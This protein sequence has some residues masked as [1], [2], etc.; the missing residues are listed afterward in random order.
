VE[1]AQQVKIKAE[2]LKLNHIKQYIMKCEPKKKLDFIKDV[3][4]SCEMT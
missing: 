1:K 2:K 3:F 4:E